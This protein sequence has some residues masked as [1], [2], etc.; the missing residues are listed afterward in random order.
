MVRLIPAHLE[1][2]CVVPDAPLPI[3]SQIRSVAVL[4]ELAEI[5]AHPKPS[6]PLQPLAGILKGCPVG[7]AREEYHDYLDKKYSQ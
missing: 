6:S 4:V 3:G 7:D 1:N 5:A 2:G